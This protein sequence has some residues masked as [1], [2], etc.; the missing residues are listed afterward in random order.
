MD[1]NLIHEIAFLGEQNLKRTRSSDA[2]SHLSNL[3]G[4]NIV[5]VSIFRFRIVLLQ[6]SASY[7]DVKS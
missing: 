2:I 4:N 5:E 6:V 7:T 3:V 1:L